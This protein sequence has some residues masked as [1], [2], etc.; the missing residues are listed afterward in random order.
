QTKSGHEEVAVINLKESGF[1]VFCPHVQVR[2][3]RHHERRPMFLGYIFVEID[4][5]DV[6]KWRTIRSHRGVIKLLTFMSGCPA[7]L[8][9]GF[10]EALKGQGDLIQKF[11][12]AVRFAKG[13]KILFTA[14]PLS[15]IEGRVQWTN[16]ERI[17]LLI[18]LLGRQRVVQTTTNFIA[19]A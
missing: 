16:K 10:V 4:L 5:L 18:D 12:D 8:P 14:G 3:A 11:D 6:G 9:E 19:P 17:S 1:N 2:R 13:Q 7:A 15:G